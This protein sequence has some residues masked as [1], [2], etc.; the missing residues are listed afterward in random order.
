M[1]RLYLNGVD[2]M[3]ALVCGAIGF[4]SNNYDVTKYYIFIY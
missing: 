3:V 2:V 4:S 1:H